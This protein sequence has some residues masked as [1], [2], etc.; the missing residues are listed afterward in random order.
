MLVLE[1]D[2]HNP[3]RGSW[4]LASDHQTPDPD[5]A[6]VLERLEISAGNCIGW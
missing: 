6:A 4:S 3:I 2:E 1:Q 5:P